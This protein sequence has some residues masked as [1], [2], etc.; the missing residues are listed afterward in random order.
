MSNSPDSSTK[1]PPTFPRLISCEIEEE[2]GGEKVMYLRLDKDPNAESDMADDWMGV[3]EGESATAT[4][5]ADKEHV[6][7]S[8]TCVLAD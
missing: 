8:L 4:N 3:L 2:G 7:L 5:Y 6:R 1:M